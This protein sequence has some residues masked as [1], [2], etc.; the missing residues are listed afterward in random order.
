MKK[1]LVVLFCLM[2]AA[3]MVF[4]EGQ[5]DA[6]SS[7]N[8]EAWPTKSINLIVP[9]SAGG[10]S[11]FNARAVAKYLP[12][13]LGQPVVVTNVPGS[14][15]TIGA[16]QVKDAKPDGYTILVHQ[17]SLSIAEAA[18]MADYGIKDFEVGSVF[19]KASPELLVALSDAPYN[20]VE[21]LIEYTQAHP[22]EVKLTANT[23]ATTMWIAIGLQN[24]GA[25][26]NVVSSGGSGER[27]QVV[28]GGHADIVP[29]N[30]G[31]VESYLNDGTLKVIGLASDKRSDFVPN[32]KTLRELGVEAG[33][34]YMNTMIFPKGTDPA[35]VEKFSNAVGEIVNN[36]EKYQAE[37]AKQ[38]QPVTWM[39]VE[40]SKAHWYN[41]REELMAISDVL[42]GK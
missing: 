1:G 22:G 3:G 31:M 15:G 35:I 28:L 21:E 17:L 6:A 41:Q 20:N 10:N 12:E 14:G 32:V 34:D 36:N 38:Y 7:E 37:I 16:A 4:A 27:L 18:G 42:Q 33:Y 5:K 25:K 26:L 30:Y 13:I 2:A 19:S 39:N 8:A 40:D 11:D 29:L 23:G 9:Y 24:A